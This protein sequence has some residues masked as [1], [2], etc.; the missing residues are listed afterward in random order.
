M[1]HVTFGVSASSLAANMSVKQNVIDYSHK[2]PIAAEV[3]KNVVDCLTGPTDSRS[4]SI[5]QPELFS[6]GV[7][8]LKKWNLTQRFS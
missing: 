4:A 3:V 1:T 2:Y 6:R 8:A 5:L 7:F